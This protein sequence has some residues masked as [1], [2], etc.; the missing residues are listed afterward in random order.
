LFELGIEVGIFGLSSM[1]DKEYYTG[2]EFE[3]VNHNDIALYSDG[4]LEKISYLKAL[5]RLMKFIKSFKP[6]IVHSHYASSYGLLGA[7]SRKHPFFI[8]LWGSDI[9]E[10]PLKSNFNKWLISFNLKHADEIFA[11]SRYLANAANRYTDKQIRISPFGV[12][13]TQFKPALYDSDLN[14]GNVNFVIG[15]IKSLEQ[16]YGIDILIKAFSILKKRN[17]AKQFMLLIVGEG[18][19]RQNLQNLV[20]ELGL[21]DCVEFKGYIQPSGILEYLN[22]INIFVNLSRRE[23]FGVSVVEA[24]AC[25][26]PVVATSVGGLPEIVVHD[27]CGILVEPENI[28][29]TAAAIESLVLDRNKRREFG[30]KGRARVEELYDWRKNIQTVLNVYKNYAK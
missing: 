15:T 6:D 29:Q 24:L 26:I 16:V 19:Q 28:Q 5:P 21:Q 22:Q 2:I 20:I 25:N 13:L 12:N 30:K 10:Y 9:L 7:L 11:T 17:P 18:T 1:D 27:Q 23:S 14:F 4:S 3:I 8:S